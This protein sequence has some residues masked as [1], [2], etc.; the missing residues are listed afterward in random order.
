MA[1]L[2]YYAVLGIT[3]QASDE[4]VKK[5]YRKLA[6]QFHPDRNRGNPGAEIKIREINAAYEVLGNPETRKSYE[7]LRF[8]GLGQS[9]KEAD[10]GVEDTIDPGV[11]FQEMEHKLQDEARKEML[12]ALIKQPKW[13]KQELQS[14]RRR[15]V[16]KLGYDAFREEY[17]VQRAKEVIHDLLPKEVRER[18]E[19]LVD[20]AL[21]MLILQ[22]VVPPGNEQEE[23][24]L[25]DQLE[26]IYDEGWIQGY[27]QAC[28]L[29]YVRR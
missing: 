13:I 18:R 16:D 19:R 10:A 20:V 25:R 15:I 22:D 5:V 24:A 3:P 11:V 14:I 21:Q 7:R 2:D 6:L 17:I 27:T 29:F 26:K 12:A 23:N 9:A 1:R 4:E 28:N 8:G